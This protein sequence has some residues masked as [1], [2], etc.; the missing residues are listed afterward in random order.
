[1]NTAAPAQRDGRRPS[2]VKVGGDLFHPR[3]PD[4]AVY[5]GRSG[6]GIR[7][8]VWANPFKA[9]R[10]TPVTVRLGGR[11]HTIGA[12]LAGNWPPTAADAVAWYEV[13][14]EHADLY[15]AIRADLAGKTLAC[16]CELGEPCHVDVLLVIANSVEQYTPVFAGGRR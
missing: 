5:C 8:S 9:K 3:V 2:R 11:T 14:V 1:M 10:V 12:P 4:G 16:W 7:G 6:P 13:L 15:D